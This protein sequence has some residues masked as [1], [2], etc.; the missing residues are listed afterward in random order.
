MTG[1]GEYATHEVLN[2]PKD[3]AGYNAYQSDAT[4]QSVVHSFDA[5]WADVHLNATGISVGSAHV[6]DLAEQANRFPPE[7]RTHDRYGH[8]IDQVDFHPAWHELMAFIIAHETHSL[9]W[10]QL[11]PG[12]HVARA[13]LLYLWSQGENGICCPI[14]MTHAA[15]PVLRKE[16]A[17]AA[18]WEP[19]LLSTRYDPRQIEAS[20]K[21]GATAGMAMTEKQ[22]GSDLRQTQTSAT[23]NG[24]GTWS[25]VGHKWFFSAP[26]SDVFLTLARTGKGVSCFVVA[27]WLPDGSRN[28]LMIQRLKNKCGN[29]SNASSE[30]E[31]RGAIGRLLGEDGHGIRMLIE[32]AHLT[33]LDCAASSAALMHHAVLRAAHHCMHRL[34]FQ[35][36][37]IDQPLMENVLADLSI[38]AQAATW[39]AFRVI[40]AR[41]REQ[42]EAERLLGRIGAPIAKYW[43]CKRAGAVVAEALECQG[44]NAFIEDNPMARLYREAPLNSL[45]EGSGN[46]ICLDVLRSMAQAP[47]ALPLLL[48]EIGKARGGDRRFDGFFDRMTRELADMQRHEGQARRLV[49][50]LALAIS[51][52][53]LIRHAPQAVADAFVAS[54]LSGTWSGH[55]GDLPAGID[56]GAL[57]HAV[58][59]AV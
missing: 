1:A 49:E 34:A 27:G 51:A 54:R 58:A 41:D 48:D 47:D 15:I 17:I 52:S 20:A 39:L 36:R 5:E 29:R 14:S 33:R 59:P 42:D 23:P 50:T 10:T 13:A 6:Q 25:L 21:S 2:Q 53:L 18:E 31:F 57:A 37:L 44:G 4:L 11:R 7:L 30:V 35:R 32:M 26:H 45:W 9:A 40:A 56:A 3:L 8:R 24:D 55:F 28:R 12:A 16:P 19:R 46:V 22:G 38:E 43:V